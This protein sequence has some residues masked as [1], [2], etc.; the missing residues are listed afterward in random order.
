MTILLT[1]K[2]MIIRVVTKRVALTLWSKSIGELPRKKGTGQASDRIN[3][4]I[5][6]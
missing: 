2:W 5:Y 1:I 6:R 4:I 3:Q